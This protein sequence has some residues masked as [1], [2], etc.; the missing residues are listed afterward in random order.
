MQD[1]SAARS[2]RWQESARGEAHSERLEA[3]QEALSVLEELR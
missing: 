2:E 1:Y 3:V